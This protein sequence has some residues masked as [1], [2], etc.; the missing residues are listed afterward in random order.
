MFV[1]TLSA[2]FDS[3]CMCSR[4]KWMHT[5]AHIYAQLHKGFSPLCAVFIKKHWC[6][7][8]PVLYKDIR[9]VNF[10]SV[11][12]NFL[13][14]NSNTVLFYCNDTSCCSLKS[15]STEKQEKFKLL[16]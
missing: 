8:S 7:N 14:L 12:C 3:I 6:Q 16:A 9:K 10:S 13:I 5:N 1:V 11:Q 2:L 15:L 4:H